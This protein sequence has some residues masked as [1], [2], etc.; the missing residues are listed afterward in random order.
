MSSSDRPAGYK[1]IETG[2]LVEL[3]IVD[4][5]VEPAP[6]GETSF[7]RIALQPVRS[8]RSICC[9]RRTTWWPRKKRWPSPTSTWQ[10]RT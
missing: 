9:R 2:T 3:E 7:V 4:T 8:R 10:S 1:L 5:K 6:D